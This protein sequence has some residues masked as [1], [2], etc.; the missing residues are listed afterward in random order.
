MVNLIGPYFFDGNINRENFI[1]F[2]RDRLLQLFEDID[3][4]R[5]KMWIQLN[6]TIPHYAAIVKTY[7]DWEYNGRWIGRRP[8]DLLI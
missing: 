1:E 3:F 8:H 5:Q 4:T 6:R 7:L 2:L